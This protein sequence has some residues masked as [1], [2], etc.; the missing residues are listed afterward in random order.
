MGKGYRKSRSQIILPPI[1]FFA[2]LG[3]ESF[4]ISEMLMRRHLPHEFVLTD[5]VFLLSVQGKRD[6]EGFTRI[7][8]YLTNYEYIF[9]SRG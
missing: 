4:Q 5:E 3:K 1:S 8:S 2:D 6:L 7:R 9:D